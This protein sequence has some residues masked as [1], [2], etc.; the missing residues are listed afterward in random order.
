MPNEPQVAADAFA[1][2]DIGDPL[3]AWLV[4]RGELVTARRTHPNTLS[5]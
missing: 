2:L 3:V 4:Y 1:Y 5:F